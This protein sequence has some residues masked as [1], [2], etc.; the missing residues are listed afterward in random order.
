MVVCSLALVGQ[1]LQGPNYMK[2]QNNLIPL[3][4]SEYLAWLWTCLELKEGKK[5]L[6]VWSPRMTEF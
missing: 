4:D 6:I 1:L 5:V 2:N 3:P